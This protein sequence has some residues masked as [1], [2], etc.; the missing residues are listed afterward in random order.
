MLARGEIDEEGWHREVANVLVPV[1]LSGENPRAQSGS[2]AD[3]TEWEESRRPLL[4]AV[5]RSGSFI[6]IGC[7]NGH[8]IESMKGWA[9]TDGIT[10]EVYGV[11][12]APEL[13]DLARRRLPEWRDRIWTGNAYD[14]EPPQLFDFVRVGLEY[15]PPSRRREFIQRLLTRYLVQGGRLVVGMHTELRSEGSIEH[16]VAEWGNVIAGHVEVPHRDPRTVRRAF[17]IDRE[18]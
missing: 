15:V 10:L 14:F 8:L 16:T 12:I 9:A 3:E 1:Y 13:A 11:E 4:R 5:D 2:S 7:A 17:W 6:D 18:R